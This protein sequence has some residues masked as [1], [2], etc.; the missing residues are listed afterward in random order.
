MKKFNYL[1]QAICLSAILFS[2][3][4]TNAQVG[5]GVKGGLNLSKLSFKEDAASGL[6]NKFLLGGAGGLVFNFKANDLFSLQPELLYS[7]QGTE[8]GATLFGVGFS[9]KTIFNYFQ[10]PVLAKLSFGSENVR[11][12]VNAGPYVGYLLSAKVKSSAMG[13]EEEEKIDFSDPS[14]KESAN[15]F[16]FGIAGGLG[17]AFKV[18][19]GDIF[20]E[21]RYN[22]GLLDI[23][24]GDVTKEPD[25]EPTKNRVINFS[26][27]YIFFFGG[28]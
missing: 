12:F 9:M 23:S 25:Y 19:P 7:S 1:K 13:Q 3:E 22:L 24:K 17:V 15:R 10:L 27:G 4:T 6:T 20:V 14:T 21:G 8:L 11:G 28:K 5:I 18:G 26:A 16:D 2:I